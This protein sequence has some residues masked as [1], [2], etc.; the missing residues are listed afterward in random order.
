VSVGNAW[1]W[2]D[3]KSTKLGGSPISRT[4]LADE[5]KLRKAKASSNIILPQQS[6]TR[7]RYFYVKA[8]LQPVKDYEGSRAYYY[9]DQSAFSASREAQV[10]FKLMSGPSI[11]SHPHFLVRSHSFPLVLLSSLVL[12]LH[13]RISNIQMTLSYSDHLF[14]TVPTTVSLLTQVPRSR[15]SSPTPQSLSNNSSHR[16]NT[17]TT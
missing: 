1:D 14:E 10:D 3:W 17:N 7:P 5:R 15:S 11:S 8:L 16:N 9:S 12:L 6:T 13:A 2:V 4:M